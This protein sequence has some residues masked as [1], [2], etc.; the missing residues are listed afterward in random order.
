MAGRGTQ[1][2]VVPTASLGSHPGNASYVDSY[3]ARLL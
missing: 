2:N 3:A 1:G